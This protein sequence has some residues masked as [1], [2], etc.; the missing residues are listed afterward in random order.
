MAPI[1]AHRVVR[2]ATSVS[3]AVDFCVQAVQRAIAEHGVPEILN[4]DQGCPFTSAEFTQPLL[5]AGVTLSMDGKGRAPD[6]VFVERLWRTVKYEEA[7]PKSY[8]SQ[9]EAD[10][11]LVALFRFHNDR[12]SHSSLGR[13]ATPTEAYPR[14]L[15]V[16]LNA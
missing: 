7:H 9:V 16:A 14:D 2:S 6:R 8:S 4:T 15:P 5:A 12:R 1:R 11:N 13:D 10:T 3:L